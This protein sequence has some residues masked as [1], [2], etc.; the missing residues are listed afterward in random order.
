MYGQT[1]AWPPQP[2]PVTP[3]IFHTRP[4]QSYRAQVDS[5]N[6]FWNGQDVARTRLSDITDGSG[7]TMM[8]SEGLVGF[9]DNPGSGPN[10]NPE[11]WPVMGDI[12]TATMGGS[13]FSA[14]NTP[15]SSAP[16]SFFGNC[17][18]GWGDHD[19]DAPCESWSGNSYTTH[20]AARSRHS[21][22]VNVSMADGS[23][24]FIADR[25]SL[26]AWRALSTRAGGEVITE[27]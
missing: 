26:T 22:G 4:N 2:R 7:N 25:I 12:T 9:Y 14:F 16:D 13:L 1:P 19:Y 11:S 18:Q 23:V 20:A 24:R 21:G 6:W 15:N 8:F 27:D 5:P 17:P 10:E 3:G